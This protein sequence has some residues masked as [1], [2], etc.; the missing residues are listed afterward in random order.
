MTEEQRDNLLIEMSN[1][2]KNINCVLDV[3]SKI[4]SAHSVELANLR[5][6]MNQ[7]KNEFT[8]RFDEHS[9]ELVRL[10]ENTARMEHDLTEK[11]M[12]L[13]DLGEVF[14]DN[15]EE[16]NLRVTEIRNTLNW[17]DRRIMKLEMAD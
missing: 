13:F 4:L 11:I 2:V 1:N 15:F 9:K 8:K 7:M 5:E 14:K 16:T 12:A 10:R 3:H 6:D 17:H